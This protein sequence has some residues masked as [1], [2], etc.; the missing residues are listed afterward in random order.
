[1]RYLASPAGTLDPAVPAA[2]TELTGFG[3]AGQRRSAMYE[4]AI[5]TTARASV[6]WPLCLLT[7]LL[8]AVFALVFTPPAAA[9][10]SPGEGAQGLLGNDVSWPQCGRHF[11]MG[12]AFAIVGVNN[13]LANTTNPCLAEQLEWAETSAGLTGQPKVALYVNTANPGHA[14]SWWPTSNEYPAGS[15]IHNPYGKCEAPNISEACAYMYGYAKAYDDA[16]VRGISKPSEYLWW[17]DVE[18]GNTWS[19]NRDANR[20]VLEGMTHFFLSIQADVGIY[21]TGYQWGQIV[22]KVSSSSSLYPLP[23][24]LAGALSAEGAKANCSNTPLTGGGRVTLTQ[25]VS[26]GFDYNHSC[27]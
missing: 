1:M 19:T 26:R 15:A 6:R 9:A 16:D 8:L 10:P 24:W 4:Y 17:L 27:G 11:P 12:Q 20:A 23:S 14:G 13:G 3:R 7:C 2:D 25:F 22:G 21:S 5:G 18:T